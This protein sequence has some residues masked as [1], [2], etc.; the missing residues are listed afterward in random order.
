MATDN[1][2]NVALRRKN[3]G[4]RDYGESAARPTHRAIED[5]RRGM[6]GSRVVRLRDATTL[7]QR[8][9]A[10]RPPTTERLSTRCASATRPTQPKKPSTRCPRRRTSA[11]TFP[12]RHAKPHRA[13][14]SLAPKGSPS[15]ATLLMPSCYAR[16]T[17]LRPTSGRPLLGDMRTFAH[18]RVMCGRGRRLCTRAATT[19]AM[20]G[21]SSRGFPPSWGMVS[22]GNM[23]AH[24]VPSASSRLQRRRAALR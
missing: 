6:Q 14:L 15:E 19:T 9:R 1:G 5:A 7:A 17:H 24:P 18:R 16:Q 20:A 2:D 23:Q 8:M 11:R 3:A 13:L 4:A 21:M 12:C 10:C 22:S